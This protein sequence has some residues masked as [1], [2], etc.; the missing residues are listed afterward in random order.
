MCTAQRGRGLYVYSTER[1]RVVCVQ[2]REAEGCMCTA[3]RGRGLYVYS[4][5]RQRV[6]CVQHR[7]AE[8]CMFLI[9]GLS[10]CQW[11]LDPDSVLR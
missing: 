10:V 2:H 8:G 4:T 1:Q 5:E 7:E 11:H 6:V 9:E 3:Q